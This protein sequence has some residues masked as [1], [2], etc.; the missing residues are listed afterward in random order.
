MLGNFGL[1]LACAAYGL[2]S[3]RG[4]ILVLDVLPR[5]RSRR[6]IPQ[7]Q[8]LGVGDR[9]QLSLVESRMPGNGHVRFEQHDEWT[10]Q[11]ATSA[12]KF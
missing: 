10:E 6:I 1:A 4:A 11:R 2:S 12:S 7:L 9:V 3:E 5:R 8:Q